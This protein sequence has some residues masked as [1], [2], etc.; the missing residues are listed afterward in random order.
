MSLARLGPRLGRGI[1]YSWHSRRLIASAAAPDVPVAIV[2]AG[3]T[4]LTLSWWLSRY[5]QWRHRAR[6]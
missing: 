2:G 1:G 5:G 4:G 6:R 3:P